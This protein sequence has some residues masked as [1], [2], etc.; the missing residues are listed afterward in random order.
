[1]SNINICITSVMLLNYY[2][3]KVNLGC[4]AVVPQPLFAYTYDTRYNA[5]YT[6]D[7]RYNAAYTY[8]TRYNAI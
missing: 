8:D 3:P 1:M 4:V 6:Y 7:T 2:W 5:A